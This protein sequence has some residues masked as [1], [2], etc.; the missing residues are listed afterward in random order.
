[1]TPSGARITKRVFAGSAQR[2]GAAGG[3][4]LVDAGACDGAKRSSGLGKANGAIGCRAG[5]LAP[6]LAPPGAAGAGAAAAG[7]E[8]IPPST[9][10]IAK[11]LVSLSALSPPLAS[12]ATLTLIVLVS[13]DVLTEAALPSVVVVCGALA[14]RTFTASSKATK[15][16][17]AAKAQGF[18]S[19]GALINL[20]MF[21]S[22]S[23]AVGWCAG[24][25]KAA[26]SGQAGLFSWLKRA[27]SGTRMHFVS[28][29]SLTGQIG[30][31]RTA[32][33]MAL[34]SRVGTSICCTKAW[35]RICGVHPLSR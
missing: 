15:Y 12:T 22:A 19:F 8:Q 31:R 18:L 10:S 24:A 29:A 35:R 23:P 6:F 21:V 33:L 13:G 7:A 9:L 32:N 2:A 28:L 16:W 14:T 4:V 25:V 30:S 27:T 5:G 17:N 11:L 26:R 3:A 1:M 20:V 34:T